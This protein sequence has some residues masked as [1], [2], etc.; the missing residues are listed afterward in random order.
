MHRLGRW[1]SGAVVCSR[2]KAVATSIARQ[3][4][5]RTMAKRY[6]ALAVGYPSQDHFN[7]NTPIGPVPYPPLGSVHA[8]S[9]GGRPASSSVRVVQRREHEFLC[10]VSIATGRPHQIR[11]HLA[12]AGHPLVG[13]P[14]YVPGGL[15]A[16]G[17][18]ALPG[19]PGYQLHSAELQFEHPV[20]G[21]R[22]QVLAPLPAA[23]QV[24]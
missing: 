14:L 11:I 10:D 13:D 20:T 6:R 5:D 21:R 1:T 22:L 18:T 4:A 15:P 2:N 23:L 24:K 17:G 16:A 9:R 12:T 3:F 19:D 8:T 7:I